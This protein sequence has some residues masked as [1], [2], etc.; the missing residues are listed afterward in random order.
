MTTDTQEILAHLARLL[1]TPT[2]D[3]LSREWNDLWSD[4]HQLA[5]VQEAGLL[6]LLQLAL[7]HPNWFIREGALELVGFHY[8]LTGAAEMLGEVRALLLSDSSEH[9]RLT[10]AA[11]LGEQANAWDTALIQALAS[12]SNE[13]VRRIAFDSLLRLLRLGPGPEARWLDEVRVGRLAPTL[14]TLRAVAARYER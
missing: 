7:Q 4:V 9:V 13:D 14:D 6:S 3:G 8:D 5:E 2:T 1:G 11:V 12:D 10:A